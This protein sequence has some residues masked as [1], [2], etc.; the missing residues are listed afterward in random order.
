MN[1][2]DGPQKSTVIPFSG[3]IGITFGTDN[4]WSAKALFDMAATLAHP[5][6]SRVTFA[7]SMSWEKEL[8]EDLLLSIAADLSY[9]TG[10]FTSFGNRYIRAELSSYME[11]GFADNWSLYV[12][13]K[14]GYWYGLLEPQLEYLQGPVIKGEAGVIRYFGTD[15]RNHL[16]LGLVSGLYLFRDEVY[17]RPVGV[18]GRYGDLA[19]TVAFSW[20]L[21]DFTL[22]LKAMYGYSRWM[23]EDN[24]IDY[25]K[26]R[27][28]HT[29][30]VFPEVWYQLPKN[31]RLGLQYRFTAN[32]SNM[33][34]D[35]LDYTEYTY[36]RHVISV[37]V[38]VAM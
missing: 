35:Y 9:E 31:F 17:S 32:F 19:A 21:D 14:A 30:A 18:S 13:A 7:G 22:M 16:R 6:C 37:L 24:F 33:G 23:N 29:I 1:G 2:E 38:S 20:G 25:Y 27:M 10:S 3:D 5:E 26:R 34:P 15:D 8:F 11:Y 28:D 36:Q 4:E 12:S